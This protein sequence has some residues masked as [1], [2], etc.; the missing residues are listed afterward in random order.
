MGLGK[1]T[2]TAGHALS[3]YSYGLYVD[4]SSVN[5]LELDGTQLTAMGGESDQYGSQGVFAGEEIIVKNGATV[6]ATGGQV[7]SSYESVGFNAVSWLTVSGENSRVLGYGGTSVK[8]DSKGVRC[9]SR[10]TLTDGC[11]FGQGGVSCTSS[12]NVGV[13]FKRL[14]ME[15]GKL[16]GI[17]G[18]PD[19]SYQTWGG[20]FNAY[21]L[22]CTGAAKIT[23][24][25]LIG[26]AN[27]TDRELDY[28]AYGFYGS[29]ELTLS[30]GTLRATTGDTPN[31]SSGTLAAI[32]VV[33]N[34]S[35][36]QLSGGTIYARAG[37]SNDDRS[38][39]MRILGTGSTL[40]MTNTE[41][42]AQ[43]LSLYVTGRNMAL[44]ATA[45]ADG[46]LLPEI[47]ASSAYDAEADTLTDG[48]TFSNKQYRKDGTAALSLSAA[49]C[50]HSASDD[51]GLCTKCGKRVYE[52]V[53]LT[54]GAVTQR[55][56]AAGEAFTAAQTEEHQ[57]CTLRLLTDL[58]DDDEPLVHDPVVTITGGRFT[59]DLHNHTIA[60]KTSDD[61]E[62][63]VTVTGG[64][65]RIENGTLENLCT[66][67]GSKAQALTLLGT[68]THVTLANVTAIGATP[69]QRRHQRLRLCPRRRP[70]H[71][72]EQRVHRPGRR[73]LRLCSDGDAPRLPRRR[74]LPQRPVLLH[75]RDGGQRRHPSGHSEGGL[76]AGPR[77]RHAGG[78]GYRALLQPPL[79]HL[80]AQR[81]GTGGG[82]HPQRPQRTAGLL[83]LRLCL[84]PRRPDTGQLL[85]AAGLLPVR[86]LLRHSP[87]GPVHAHRQDHHR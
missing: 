15:S 20:Q 27:G 45:L 68:G 65:L 8:G 77:R 6:T 76:C 43:P 70:S 55:Y 11:V 39:G 85:Y 7:N 66:G 64:Q 22:Y 63:V 69:P 35:K 17:S 12:R 44:Y 16:E 1:V 82:P 83:W 79:R 23:G 36:T 80:Y 78:S 60:G 57:G 28:S 31:A 38:Y 26:T 73:L 32:S 25:E 62:G 13:E 54:D 24:G 29:D 10:F 59:L 56:A 72:R 81:R 21:G 2:A 19:S 47:T 84:P 87:Q 41:D 30:G 49:A 67:N 42:A 46:G 5:A 75:P 9:G 34:K 74:H 52:A 14:I 4:Y 3:R 18:S 61:K 51:T 71:H 48:Y 37:I 58:I 33:S 53:L 86:H 50:L 40:T